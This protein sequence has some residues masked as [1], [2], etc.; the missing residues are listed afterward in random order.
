MLL[1]GVVVSTSVQL[2]TGKIIIFD[3]YLTKK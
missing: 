3:N 1:L 2:G